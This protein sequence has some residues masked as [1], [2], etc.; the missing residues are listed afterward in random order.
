MQLQSPHFLYNFV[1]IL[2]AVYQQLFSGKTER[3]KRR[4]KH[5]HCHS[6]QFKSTFCTLKWSGER[7]KEAS[8][9]QPD[10]PIQPRQL[11]LCSASGAS[12]KAAGLWF[13]SLSQ[14]RGCVG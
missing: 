13:R 12:A 4:R 8:S 9:A 6:V 10:G 11:A 1:L 2:S 5:I 3:S 14:L 7:R